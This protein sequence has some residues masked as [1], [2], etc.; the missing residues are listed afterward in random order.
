MRA[1]QRAGP[2]RRSLQPDSVQKGRIGFQRERNR[3]FR[4]LWGRFPPSAAALLAALSSA[5]VRYSATILPSVLRACFAMLPYALFGGLPRG[6]CWGFSI[7]GAL[8]SQ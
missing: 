2:L 6:A 5:S 1:A 3:R 8:P 7:L 4:S